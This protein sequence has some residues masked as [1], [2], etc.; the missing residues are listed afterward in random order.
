M[1]EIFFLKTLYTFFVLYVLCWVLAMSPDVCSV[2]LFGFCD[3][4]SY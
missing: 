2:N 4:T 1:R 3:L